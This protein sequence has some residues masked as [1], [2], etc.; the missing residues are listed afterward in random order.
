MSKPKIKKTNQTKAFLWVYK[1][2]IIHL[3]VLLI[4]MFLFSLINCAESIPFIYFA[5]VNVFFM[6]IYI[7]RGVIHHGNLR[8]LI[9]KLNQETCDF[10]APNTV[11][12]VKETLSSPKKISK[13]KNIL[14]R[15]GY[16][17]PEKG[18]HRVILINHLGNIIGDF[19]ERDIEN[20]FETVE[21]SDEEDYYGTNAA[22]ITIIHNP[23]KDW[24]WQE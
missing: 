18:F 9:K 22:P 17:D 7:K 4:G 6:I 24:I 1:P 20:W 12:K 11:L 5:I 23:N 13:N 2:I 21:L 3:P 15:V 14:C 19:D 8:A 10:L 16:Y